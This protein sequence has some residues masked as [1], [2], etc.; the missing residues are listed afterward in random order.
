MPILSP[1]DS[2]PD[3]ARDPDEVVEDWLNVS[4][5]SR[6]ETDHPTMDPSAVAAPA[7]PREITFEGVLRI[8]GYAA[9][10]I[11]SDEGSLVV[12]ADGEV[13]ADISVHDATIHGCVRGDIRAKR[14]VELCGSARVV[15]DIE[16]VALSIEPGAVFEGRCI[17]VQAPAAADSSSPP[18]PAVTSQAP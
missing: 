11:R 14:K 10:V 8:N 2:R 9:G 6:N 15:G 18:D 4:D 7:Q 5:T 3:L 16:T 13:D 1:E 12:E 17:F